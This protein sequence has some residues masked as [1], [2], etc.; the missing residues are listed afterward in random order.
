MK[1]AAIT[2][3]EAEARIIRR[4]GFEARASG[5]GAARTRELAQALLAEGAEGLVSFGIAGAL[6]PHLAPGTLLSPRVVVEEG[7]VRHLVNEAWRTRVYE[8]L[9]ATR[10]RVDDGDMLCAAAIAGTRERKAALFA[11]TGAV[12]VDLESSIVAD[13]AT[14]AGKPFLILRAVADHAAQR[15][16]PAVNVGLDEYGAPAIASV[17]ASL[18]R[19]PMQIPALLLVAAATRR[20]LAALGSALDEGSIRHGLLAGSIAQ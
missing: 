14:R 20:A 1:I 7:G 2:G 19:N 16:P 18:A 17:L 9:A 8:A 4:A 5:G 6:S 12:A 3:L 15:L 10:L 13:M 11:A